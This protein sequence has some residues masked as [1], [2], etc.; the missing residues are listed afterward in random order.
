MSWLV[1]GLIVFLSVHS[2]AIVAP[3]WR[4]RMYARLGDPGWK[5]PYALLSILGFAMILHGYP[6]AN[7]APVLLHSPPTWTR[8]LAVVLMLPVFPLLLAAY[9]P[10]RIKSFAKHPLLAATIVWGVAH[11]LANGTVPDL[12]L[13]GGFLAWAVADRL[14]VAKRA[15]RAVPSAP[16]GRWNDAIALVVGLVL[17]ATLLGGLHAR[18]FG[19]SPL[20]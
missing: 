13:F 4:D 5:G 6:I 10:G 3:A 11:V 2:V 20:G 7:R 18:L 14:A 1:V 19:V 12:L 17:Y 15:P 16:A 8:H 9:L